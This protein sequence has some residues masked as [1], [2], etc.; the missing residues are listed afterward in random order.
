VEPAQ[1]SQSARIPRHYCDLAISG[2]MLTS[3]LGREGRAGCAT[4]WLRHQ[5]LDWAVEYIDPA[6][7]PKAA[8]VLEEAG[9]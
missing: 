3:P 5:G 2:L 6:V 1:T 9:S 7:E 4:G 8:A